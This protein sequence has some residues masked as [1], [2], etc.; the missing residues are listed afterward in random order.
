MRLTFAWLALLTYVPSDI[1]GWHVQIE[2]A[3]QQDHADTLDQVTTE[4][5]HQL[6]QIERKVPPKAVEKLRRVPI[7]IHY[8]SKTP[9]MTYHPSRQWLEEHGYNPAMARGV[10]IGN[11]KT[12]LDWTK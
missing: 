8:N 3:F 10:E 11:A 2:R 9:C 7:W 6:Y 5:R 12:F 1:E 4:L